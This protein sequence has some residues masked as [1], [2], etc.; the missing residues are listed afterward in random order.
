MRLNIMHHFNVQIAIDYSIE[1]AIF[2]NNIYFWMDYNRK[3]ERHYYDGRYWT[4]NSVKAFGGIFPYWSKDQ[5]GRLLKKML[6]N[7]LLLKGNYNEKGL[8]QTL[9]YTLSDKSLSYMEDNSYYPSQNEEIIKPQ[10]VLSEEKKIKESSH[11]AKSRNGLGQNREMGKN[12]NESSSQLFEVTDLP[13]SRN[14]EL[15]LAE[16]RNDIYITDNKHTD[17]KLNR[18]NKKNKSKKEKE[19]ELE[20]LFVQFKKPLE[21]IFEFWKNIF[22]KDGKTR[23]TEIRKEAVVNILLRYTTEEVK[24]AVKACAASEFHVTRGHTDL[25]FICKTEERFDDFLKRA[26][27]PS[28]SNTRN[29]LTVETFKVDPKIFGELP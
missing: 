18:D 4:Y 21:E 6:E 19:K 23:F 17:N 12:L 24:L 20:K 28:R 7:G 5:I 15:H 29:N 22:D 16:S 9:W 2:I 10:N 1:E 26:K 3:N 14:R 25:L 8:N 13:I 27:L 11:F